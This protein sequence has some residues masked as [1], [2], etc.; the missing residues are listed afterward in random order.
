M[1]PQC[2]SATDQNRFDVPMNP[3][4]SSADHRRQMRDLRAD[5][6]WETVDAV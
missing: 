6:S 2:T 1:K 3:K 5:Y 4:I